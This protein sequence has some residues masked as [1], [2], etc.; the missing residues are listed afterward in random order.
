M[1]AP[2]LLLAASSSTLCAAEAAQ[3]VL[4]DDRAITARFYRVPVTK[5]WRTGLTLRVHVGKSGRSYWFLPWQGGTN[6]Q[7]NLAWVRE[8]NTP[9]Q[10]QGVRQDMEFFET[11]AAYRFI[12]EVPQAG[13][14]APARLLLPHLGELAWYSTHYTER[15]SIPKAFFDRVSCTAP[16]DGVRPRI[17]FP[18]VP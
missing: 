8:K 17:E 13:S 14:Q 1:L 10:H 9:L 16:N 7:I 5:D 15:D 3:Y 18:P 4:R 11:D 12:H 2:L 6:D